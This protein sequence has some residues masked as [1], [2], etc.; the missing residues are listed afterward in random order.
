MKFLCMETSCSCRGFGTLVV[1]CMDS[2]TQIET[3]SSTLQRSSAA[4]GY[5]KLKLWVK[6][7]IKWINRDL[8][9]LANCTQPKLAGVRVPAYLMHTD[10]PAKASAGSVSPLNPSSVCLVLSCRFPRFS[11]AVRSWSQVNP[12]QVFD[13]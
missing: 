11:K 3:G 4:R 6:L 13:V 2:T 1:F 7:Y 10:H 9:L 5:S 8:P 12:S